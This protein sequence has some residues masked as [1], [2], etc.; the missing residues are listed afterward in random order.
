[1]TDRNRHLATKEIPLLNRFNIMGKMAFAL[2]LVLVFAIAGTTRFRQKSS[3]SQPAVKNEIKQITMSI[4]QSD[5]E[6]LVRYHQ[7]WIGDIPCDEF[8]LNLPFEDEYRDN[9]QPTAEDIASALINVMDMGWDCWFFRRPRELAFENDTTR[10]R[11]DLYLGHF[12][13]RGNEAIAPL[14]IVWNYKG[15][16]FLNDPAVIKLRFLRPLY[17]T[18]R[19]W[20]PVSEIFW[21]VDSPQVLLR[22]L[23]KIQQ[24]RQVET[25]ASE[26]AK[27]MVAPAT[28]QTAYGHS[29]SNNDFF[30]D[31][32]LQRYRRFVT[33]KSVIHLCTK[34][35]ADRYHQHA[36]K[37]TYNEPYETRNEYRDNA[38]GYL[39]YA[40]AM[41][42][43]LKRPDLTARCLYEKLAL[44]LETADFAAGKTTLAAAKKQLTQK[45]L[46]DPKVGAYLLCAS[47]MLDAAYDH[48]EYSIR[49]LQWG[50]RLQAGF[51]DT[52][53]KTESLLML[54]KCQYASKRYIESSRTYRLAKS[55][56]VKDSGFP[57]PI[58]LLPAIGVGINEFNP[59]GQLSKARHSQSSINLMDYEMISHSA[60]ASYDYEVSDYQKIIALRGLALSALSTDL[61]GAWQYCRE[62][63]SKSRT[64]GCLPYEDDLL[65][66]SARIWASMKRTPQTTS[67]ALTFYGQI[68]KASADNLDA[69]ILAKNEPDS[70]N[71]CRKAAETAES[72]GFLYYELGQHNRAIANYRIVMNYVKWYER[73][74]PRDRQWILQ[75]KVFAQTNIAGSYAAMGAYDKCRLALAEAESNVK[76]IQ[77]QTVLTDNLSKIAETN[78]DLHNLT[79][80]RQQ[81][82][83]V[84]M[85]TR[86]FKSRSLEAAAL[87]RLGKTEDSSDNPL[88]AVK[89]YSECI[90]KTDRDDYRAMALGGLGL[91]LLQLRQYS[92]AEKAL[93][94]SLQLGKKRGFEYS[95]TRS[96]TDLAYFYVQRGQ[97]VKAIPLY[98]EAATRMEKMTSETVNPD[99]Q[100][101][102]RTMHHW[103]YERLFTSLIKTG[104][105]EAAWQVAEASRTQK[106]GE[107]LQSGWG[108]W[109]KSLTTQEK[110][111]HDRL[112]NRIAILH[113]AIREQERQPISKTQSTDLA[114]KL[115]A[116]EQNLREWEEDK[117]A[118]FSNLEGAR[119]TGR[120]TLS[121]A[122]SLLPDHKTVVV[123]Y[124]IAEQHLYA[125]TLRRPNQARKRPLEVKKLKF[126]AP[127]LG[128]KS[129]SDSI[130]EYRKDIQLETADNKECQQIAKNL[131][132]FLI[133]PL[134]A[135][136]SGVHQVV[137]IG[138]GPLL[139]LPFDTLYKQ[140]YRSPLIK[141]FA[142]SYAPSLGFL[143]QLKRSSIKAQRDEKDK[144]ALLPLLAMAPFSLSLEKRGTIESGENSGAKA[145]RSQSSAALGPQL[146][147]I[148]MTQFNALANSGPEIETVATTFSGSQNALFYSLQGKESTFKRL[149][150]KY[151]FIH[152]ATHGEFQDA[153][154]MSS[155]IALAPDRRSSGDDG[156][157]RADEIAHLEP[158][159]QADLV[160]L[161]ACESGRGKNRAGEGLLGLNWALF[162]GGAKASIVSLWPID[163]LSTNDMMRVFYLHLRRG[164]SKSEALRQAQL[165]VM[166]YKRNQPRYWA[167]FVFTGLP[168]APKI[169]SNGRFDLKH[170]N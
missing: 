92:S 127:A 63:L 91:M 67:Y 119:Q 99:L 15:Y 20:R 43:L 137:F 144:S 10:L 164:E 7:N 142:V 159:M 168:E 27:R 80:A 59:D 105:V 25:M 111:E 66:D 49:N 108:P 145:A 57:E 18:E 12:T 138:D 123:E 140:D 134:E 71:N 133:A 165:F 64:L 96:L 6:Y 161:S 36:F 94:Q 81:C 149:A 129:L 151:R 17:G 121:Q 143:W 160:V 19:A 155:F 110:S 95:Y 85:L 45:E 16:K 114:K 113:S 132:S 21:K 93:R 128:N 86:R 41:A 167:P 50:L 100:I 150:S 126:N 147:R 30:D 87:Y 115:E 52:Y 74:N 135:R 107:I 37:A 98:R 75:R 116:A 124:F 39:S 2:A 73:V 40:R 97:T 106:L 51:R 33:A 56:I 88:K 28:M 3:G 4:R 44:D 148:R 47:A 118:K 146:D 83:E 156:F 5:E 153:D 8:K 38:L 169:H 53:L 79:K 35:A 72:I 68:L 90:A 31:S 13:I 89:Y 162:A 9:D 55:S 32:I 11:P 61:S 58:S 154:P 1:M 82:L 139:R 14:H 170:R 109:E 112:Y 26:D 120:V 48:Y 76:L 24:E 70:I 65:D 157:L 103:I 34:A 69:A 84:L 130:D 141:S 122:L 104:Q 77:D 163:D 101:Q 78:C 62:A 136:L 22:T 102:W 131:Y 152:L 166:N 117:A 46:S 42:R 60:G 54:A 29:G 158:K 125:F 23:D